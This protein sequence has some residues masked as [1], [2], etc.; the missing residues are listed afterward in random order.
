[1]KAIIYVRVSTEEQAAKGYSLPTQ[2]EACQ[3]YS[4]RKGYDVLEV[5]QDKYTGT[6]MDRPG[7]NALRGFIAE[8]EINIV[9]V[10][11]IDRLSRKAIHQMLIE[12][13]L[14]N[15]GIKVEYVLGQY[16]DTDEGRLQKQIRASIAEYEK[17]KILERMKRGKFGK[18]KSGSVIV[19]ARPPYGYYT[20]KEGNRKWF[21]I[22]EEESSIVRLIFQLYV[23][24]DGKNP[25]ISQNK[26]AAKLTEMKIPTRGDKQTHVAKKMPKYTWR[27]A[28]IRSIL[29]QFA[30]T[31]RWPYGKT[32]KENGKQ[33]SRDKS[34]WVWMEVPKIIDQETFDIVQ[35]I[36]QNNIEQSKRNTK[37]KYLLR[38]RL[39]CSKCGYS[40]CGRTRR[41]KNQ[42]YY[43]K[44]REQRP[45]SLCDMPHFRLDH[46]NDAIWS[47]I[48]DLLFDPTS[49]A[50]GLKTQQWFS[51]QAN[52]R[53]Q[54]KLDILDE[55]IKSN[56]SKLDKLIDL[57]IEGD[58]P[59]DKITKRRQE[60]ETSL[61]EL[62]KE[63]QSL[64]SELQTDT[65]SDEKILELEEFVDVVRQGIQVADFETKRRIIDLLDVRG[66]LAIENEEKVVHVICKLEKQQRSLVQTSPL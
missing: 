61:T 8:N 58:F 26:I 41:K 1:M 7:L 39:K 24:G 14:E 53:V 23:H 28:T 36:V 10:Y 48:E 56:N 30:Y 17:A 64:I 9:I 55:Q 63:K 46:V 38:S 27:P 49:L 31:G 47:W 51:E 59:R 25:P 5:F 11:D 4:E 29:R 12:D 43:C 66:K 13:E 40:Y 45:I 34:E 37:N 21:V 15:E 2:I 22:D 50:E 32:K 16:Q 65:V 35:S 20:E 18:A 33:V 44:G 57:A 6:V 52:A 19:G 62:E 3:N 54:T 60:I 42:Y